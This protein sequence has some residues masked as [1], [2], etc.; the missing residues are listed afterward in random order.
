MIDDYRIVLKEEAEQLSAKWDIS[1]KLIKMFKQCYCNTIDTTVKELDDESLFVITGDIEAMWLRDSAAQV[2]H[3]LPA[4]EKSPAIYDLIKRVLKKQFFYINKDSYANAFNC[5]ANG[6][7]YAE[8]KSG[9]TDWTWERKYEVDSLCFPIDLAYQLW[10]TTMREEHLDDSFKLG[11]KKILK[12][13]KIEQKHEELS[14]YRFERD[15]DRDTETLR[16]GGLGTPVCFTGMT[17]SGFRSSDDACTYGYLI[18][19]NMYAVVVL[20]EISEIAHDIYHD[21]NM[22]SEAEML[23]NEIENGIEEFGIVEHETYGKVYAYE[24]DGFGNALLMDDAGVP[25]LLSIPYFKYCDAENQVYKN[26]RKMVL[27]KSNPYYFEGRVLKGIGSPHTKP[28][29][30]WPMG[31]IV[32]GI[33]STDRSEALEMLKMLSESDAGTGYIHE[34]IYKDDEKIYTRSWFAWANSFFSEFLMNLE[35]DD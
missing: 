6:R 22:S 23:A 32:Q 15:T 33:T 27:S 25:G 9:Q 4:A 7:H 21:E 5:E 31:L 16:R 8:D 3:Y 24:V 19:S 14:E 2:H 17:W 18:P 20:R 28:G 34:S 12:Q 30:V 11:I 29:H 10:K 35:S 1:D 13:W 26:T